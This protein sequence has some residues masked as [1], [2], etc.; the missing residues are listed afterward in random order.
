MTSLTKNQNNFFSLQMQRLAESFEGLNSSLAQSSAEILPHTNKW[1]LL[2][3]SLSLMEA[4]VLTMNCTEDR[5][6]VKGT[7][8]I[9]FISWTHHYFVAN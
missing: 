2:D 5:I 9:V 6:F 7:F 4:K 3:F 1:K 8:C